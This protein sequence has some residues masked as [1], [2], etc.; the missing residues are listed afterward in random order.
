MRTSNCLRN[1]ATAILAILVL[2]AAT[3]LLLQMPRDALWRYSWVVFPGVFVAAA[4]A[5]AGE[6]AMRR[7]RMKRFRGGR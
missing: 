1:F 7:R 6:G 5:R 3:I 2:A 4:V